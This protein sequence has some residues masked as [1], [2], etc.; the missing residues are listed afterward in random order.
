MIQVQIA[1]HVHAQGVD[2]I[3]W[4]LIEPADLA[5]ATQATASV[6]APTALSPPAAS[7]P[8]SPAPAAGWALYLFKS[9]LMLAGLLLALWLAQREFGPP[10]WPGSAPARQQYQ[11]QPQPQPQPQQ[12][13][14]P[15]AAVEVIATEHRP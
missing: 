8:A 2:Q 4:V 15:I 14:R 5:D 9:L 13:A 7:V 12:P 3:R 6:E 11:P 10:G 1:S